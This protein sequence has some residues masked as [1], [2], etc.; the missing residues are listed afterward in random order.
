MNGSIGAPSRA[1]LAGLRVVELARIL[2]GPWAGQVLADLGAEVIKVEHPAGDDTR[3]WGPP[4]VEYADGGRDA[5]YFHACNRGKRSV[6]ADLAT[7]AGA[8]FVRNLCLSADVVIENFK[9]GDLARHGLDA[10]TL[11]AERPSLIYCSITGFGQDGPY[12]DLPGYDFVIQAMGGIMDL[13][14]DPA[15]PPQKPGVAYA[16]LFTGLYAV[17]AIQG[18]LLRRAQGGEGATL[19]LALLDTQIGVLAN[20]AMNFLVS[21]VAPRRMGNAH[22]NLVPYQVFDV[23]DGPLVIAV[24]NDRQFRRLVDLL[25]IGALADDPRACTNAARVTNRGF[26]VDAVQ[27]ACAHWQ[28]Q[29]LALQLMSRGV[30]AGAINPIADAFADPQV[31]FR[32]MRGTVMSRDG[33]KVPAVRIPVRFDGVAPPLASAAPRLG[34]HQA[35]YE[36]QFTAHIPDDAGDDLPN[37]TQ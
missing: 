35:Q 22:P 9:R 26:V 5:A 11:R 3:H 25:G 12:A 24:G 29:P 31:A 21:G 8:A 16:D 36:R 34:E 30:P 14:G 28:R 37:P 4:F 20:Q 10:A 1:P 6:V 13:T 18:A 19:D 2:A 7:T 33:E 17:V 23:A 32:Q 15:G 27:S